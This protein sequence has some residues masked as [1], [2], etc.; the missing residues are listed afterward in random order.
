MEIIFICTVVAMLLKIAYL[1]YKYH[2]IADKDI[3]LGTIPSLAM[4]AMRHAL[5][6]S[7]TGM[8]LGGAC[9]GIVYCLAKWR[10][11]QDAFGSGDVTLFLFLGSIVGRKAFAQWAVLFSLLV[12]F[13]LVPLHLTKKLSWAKAVPLAPFLNI[14]TLF[15]LL[16]QRVLPQVTFCSF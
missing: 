6:N 5:L 14:I 11:G 4:H 12:I 13:S 8:L 16:G 2:Y 9:A 15:W 3:L 1:D 10:Y 7:V